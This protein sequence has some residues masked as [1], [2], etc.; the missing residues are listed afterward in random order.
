[1]EWTKSWDEISKGIIHNVSINFDAKVH[2]QSGPFHLLLSI[3]CMDLKCMDPF[4]RTVEDR[5]FINLRVVI[6][7]EYL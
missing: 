3:A 5:K 7:I 1:M 2:G 6:K 4:S